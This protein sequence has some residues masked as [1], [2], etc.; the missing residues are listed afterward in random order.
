[1]AG[2][3]MSFSHDDVVVTILAERSDAALS[4]SEALHRVVTRYDAI[5]RRS[6]PVLSDGEWWVLRAALNGVY[7]E[8]IEVGA[9]ALPHGV[10]DTLSDASDAREI[11]ADRGVDRVAFV[12]R[13]AALTFAERVAV[14]DAVE[15]WWIAQSAERRVDD[16]RT[17]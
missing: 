9:A 1:M 12:A 5:L 2:R 10:D 13:L 16:Q 15:R 11:A 4:R 14:V 7:Q 8:P 6:L 17:D 3:T